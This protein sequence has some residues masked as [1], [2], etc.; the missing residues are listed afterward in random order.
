MST[1]EQVKSAESKFGYLIGGG[2]HPYGTEGATA[3]VLKV[4]GNV[5]RTATGQD[6]ETLNWTHWDV[7]EFVGPDSYTQVAS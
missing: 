7:S 1:Q 5:V 6:L 4:G 2:N 3:V